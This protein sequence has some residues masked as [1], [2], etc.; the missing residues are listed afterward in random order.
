MTTMTWF[1]KSPTGADVEFCFDLDVDGPIDA[2]ATLDRNLKAA[3][4][5]RSERFDRPVYAGP[6]FGGGKPPETAPPADLVVQEC[7]KL[8]MRYIPVRE[9]TGDKDGVAAHW[10]CR[11]GRGCEKARKVGDRIFPF[12]NW[13]LTK[14]PPETGPP[15]QLGGAGAGTQAGAAPSSGAPD[16]FDYGAFWRAATPLGLTQP[17][18]QQLCDELGIEKTK[19]TDDDRRILLA[20][21]KRKKE[22]A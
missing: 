5:T 20:A 1:G 19:A 21:W 11:K 22:T 2:G 4:Y 15:G 18:L 16:P 10:D 7:C 17:L 13:H 6:S 8:P 3:G 9:A 12:T 14:K